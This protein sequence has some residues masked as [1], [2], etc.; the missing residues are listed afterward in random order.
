MCE[1]DM[2]EFFDLLDGACDLNPNWKRIPS[3]GKAFFFKAMEAY[4]LA[5]VA[6]ALTAH[7]R[8]PKAGMFQPTP[9]HLIAQ[10][11]VQAGRDGRPSADEAWAVALVSRDEAETVVWIS[12]AAQ[13]FGICRPV[14]QLGD[15]VGAR[16]AFIE[17]YNRLVGEARSAG[18]AVEWSASLGWDATRRDVAITRARNA[19]LLSAPAAAALLPDP[20]GESA[21][22]DGLKRVKQ[23]IAKLR[24]TWE[25]NAA[26]RAT[27]ADA[28]RAETSRRKAEIA[29]QVSR[30]GGKA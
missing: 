28:R 2:D 1:N 17:A 26:R 23:E 7:V 30:H 18:R 16:R 27:E 22:P 20:S 3:A 12:E 8:D 19:G 29:D 9:A 25:A 11:Q 13:A 10:I 4:S 21:C 15:E 14:L 6:H 24:D 5:Q